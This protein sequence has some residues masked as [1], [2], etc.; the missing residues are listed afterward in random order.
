M[1]ENIARQTRRT[2]ATRRPVALPE[3]QAGAPSRN[4][5]PVSRAI[6]W[7]TA[8]AIAATL[9]F[10]VAFAARL[11][12]VLFFPGIN[13]A[14]EVFQT[15]EQAH[16]VVFGY[17][18][19][20]WEFAY[21]TRSWILP[22]ALAGLMAFAS[23]LGDGPNYYMPVI[24]SALAAL[25]AATALCG[26]WWGRQFFGTAGGLIVGILTAV[27]IDAVY[28]GPRPLSDS[29]AAHI[30][31]IGFYTSTPDRQVGAG[32]R[33]A[34][35]GGALLTLAGALRVQL[36]PAIA[37]V[38]LWQLFTTF[39]CQRL[40]FVLGGV[41]I[42]LLYGALDGLTWSYPFEALWRNV[43]ANLYYGVQGVY[44][45]LP[46]DWYLTTVWRYWTGLSWVLLA[47]SLIGA[48]RLPQLLVAAVVI[49]VTH[50]LVGHKEFRFIYPTLLLAVIL[51]GLG[52]AQLVSWIS[53]ALC[54]KGWPH[55]RA[56]IATTGPVIAFVLLA[57]LALGVC[58]EPYHEL[59]T[60]GRD[61]VMA[62]RYVAS[63]SSVC[64][65]GLL[66]QGWSFNGGYAWFHHPVPLYW[67]MPGASLDPDS[68]GFNTVVYN[69]RRP[70]AADYTMGACF[71]DLC[72]AQR[73]GP[74]LPVPMADASAPPSQLG[75][76]WKAEIER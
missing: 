4:D 7:V 64:G 8:D 58:S 32:W 48:I 42:G 31:V 51:G 37:V 3:H 53:D 10:V 28:F 75:D 29:V 55:Q 39:R 21:G 76:A 46:W 20:P 57:Q 59:W 22:G 11:L 27:W 44:G 41:L 9:V 18:L 71:G 17:G 66:S 49:A 24:G 65:I 63:M 36:M 19:V 33:L 15:V 40:A 73:K 25:G 61:A 35:A 52:L 34:A 45:V 70:L 6:G 14:D 60:R 68:V 30:L 72:V 62:A 74:C 56:A 43:I 1:R 12:P 16:R 23:L 2:E 67:R 50:S 69:R 38:G 5:Q 13:H 54:N 47:L 26:F